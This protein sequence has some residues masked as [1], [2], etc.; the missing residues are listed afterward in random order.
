VFVRGDI[1]NTIPCHPTQLYESLAYLMVFFLLYWMY[2]KKDAGKYNGLLTGVGFLGIFISR[3]I[4]EII[5]NPQSDFEVE[6][7]YNMGQWLS[8]PFIIFGAILVVRA[9]IKGPVEYHLPKT[10]N[11]KS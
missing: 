1:N 7:T 10:V 2:W 5:K 11:K 4:I 6:M 9:L 3:Q 8:V